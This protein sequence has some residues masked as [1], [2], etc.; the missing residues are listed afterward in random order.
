MYVRILSFSLPGP[1][2][3][4]NE[5]WNWYWGITYVP[6]LW[7]M[8]SLYFFKFFWMLV[9]WFEPRN[10]LDSWSV[11]RVHH[12]VPV[13]CVLLLLRQ[14]PP[15]LHDEDA[16]VAHVTVTRLRQLETI[17]EIFFI[18]DTAGK[19]GAERS[20]KF[21]FQHLFHFIMCRKMIFRG[22][23]STYLLDFALQMQQPV[24]DRNI[25]GLWKAAILL[26]GN[27]SGV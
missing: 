5:I 1:I 19:S 4:I 16:R 26:P 2:W 27:I 22:S 23:P 9:F 12:M 15:P 13:L 3:K 20:R 24:W 18:L 14:V 21:Q 6:F 25:F 17:C 7:M 10:V 11:P 8:F